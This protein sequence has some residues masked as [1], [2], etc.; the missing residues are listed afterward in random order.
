VVNAL[1]LARAIAALVAYIGTMFVLSAAVGQTI[2]LGWEI[3]LVPLELLGGFVIGSY[4]TSDVLAGR[5][6]R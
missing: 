2:G 6:S 1:R 3:T 4:V 5:R